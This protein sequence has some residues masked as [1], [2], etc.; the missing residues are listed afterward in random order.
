MVN[1]HM[2]I[3]STSKK[4]KLKP[5]WGIPAHLSEGKKVKKNSNSTK[6]LRGCGET[7]SVTGGNVKCYSLSGKQI[8]SLL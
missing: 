7:G 6:C 5:Q 1:K 4:H 3:C 2:E 8:G